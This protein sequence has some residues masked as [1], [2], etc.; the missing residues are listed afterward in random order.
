MAK[1]LEQ[2]NIYFNEYE[3]GQT[4]RITVYDQVYTFEIEEH[5]STKQIVVHMYD[6]E[7]WSSN[8]I[9]VEIARATNMNDMDLIELHKN[10]IRNKPEFR[11]PGPTNQELWEH[12]ALAIAWEEFQIIRRLC[13]SQQVKTSS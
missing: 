8:R 1:I 4:H 13:G 5:L 6:N 10:T 9:N 2:K 11:Y 7:Y 3:P 12:P